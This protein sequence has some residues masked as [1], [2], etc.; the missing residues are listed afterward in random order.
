MDLYCARSADISP[1]ADIVVLFIVAF[2]VVVM[3]V[4]LSTTSRFC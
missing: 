3:D 1:E 2:F 4:V